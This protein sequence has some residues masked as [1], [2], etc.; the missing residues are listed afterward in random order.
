M[1]SPAEA[2][3]FGGQQGLRYCFF[4]GAVLPLPD[5]PPLPDVDG[6]GR[7][8]DGGGLAFTLR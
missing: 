7:A 3:L 2:G 6:H 8:G 1:K 4:S 5:M